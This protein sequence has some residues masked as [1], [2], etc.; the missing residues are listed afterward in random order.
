MRTLVTGSIPL[1]DTG[2][3]IILELY[4]IN[5]RLHSNSIPFNSKHF[6]QFL[7]VLFASEHINEN[8]ERIVADHEDSGSVV[9]HLVCDSKQLHENLNGKRHGTNDKE[10]RDTQQHESGGAV[11]SLAGDAMLQ[12]LKSSDGIENHH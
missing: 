6:C 1:I 10:D 8:V 5:W 2:T 12:K 11:S 9:E 7:S 3:S 4:C